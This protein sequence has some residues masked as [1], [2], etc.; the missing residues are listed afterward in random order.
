VLLAW[1][2]KQ[3]AGKITRENRTENAGARRV[4]TRQPLLSA[5]E[6]GSKGAKRMKILTT[7]REE[8]RQT[9]EASHSVQGEHYHPQETRSKLR[10]TSFWLLISNKKTQNCSY[11]TVGTR[12]MKGSVLHAYKS[13]YLHQTLL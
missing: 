7:V 3:K 12:H 13:V 4:S 2:A 5:S 11:K 1:R 10:A 6:V 9:W 8:D